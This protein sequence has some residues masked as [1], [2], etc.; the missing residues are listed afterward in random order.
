MHMVCWEI[1]LIGVSEV[2]MM[3]RPLLARYFC[4]RHHWQ[5][6]WCRKHDCK[7]NCGWF[8]SSTATIESLQPLNNSDW[9]PFFYCKNTLDVRGWCS[10]PPITRTQKAQIMSSSCFFKRFS[11]IQIQNHMWIPKTS[12]N[13]LGN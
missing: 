3:A 2:I 4:C 11:E 10:T 6:L 7:N 9:G 13:R 8:E 1:I 5:L 12:Q